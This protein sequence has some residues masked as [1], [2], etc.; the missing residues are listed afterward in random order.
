MESGFSYLKAELSEQIKIIN[1]C[2]QDIC[3]L[4]K[5]NLILKLSLSELEEKGK[6]SAN[7][8]IPR[9]EENSQMIAP[10]DDNDDNALTYYINEQP[11]IVGSQD[12][13]NKSNCEPF[14]VTN[15]VEK[16]PS[17]DHQWWSASRDQTWTLS[18][19]GFGK[20][21]FE[22]LECTN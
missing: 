4:T 10:I 12:H 21:S 9:C 8:C 7:E 15:Y 18:F 19:C 17:G 3:K 6:V 22:G 1:A 5:E 13:N 11:T 16:P 14:R 20:F 2:K